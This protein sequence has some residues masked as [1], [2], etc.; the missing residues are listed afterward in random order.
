MI[1]HA[2]R[3]MPVMGCV[4]ITGRLRSTAFM[5]LLAWTAACSGTDETDIGDSMAA[6][7]NAYCDGYPKAIEGC[8]ADT[9]Y[10][11]PKQTCK[12]QCAIYFDTSDCRDE[13]TAFGAC[14][15]QRSFACAAG[16]NLYSV[17]VPDPCEAHEDAF[18]F[19][20]G[21]TESVGRCVDPAKL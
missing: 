2:S 21:S 10:S 3:R 13:M 17:T 4:P 6:R 5:M 20:P 19:T 7:C 14:N 16:S 1:D 18:G 8:P 11:A 9:D 15:T 12:S